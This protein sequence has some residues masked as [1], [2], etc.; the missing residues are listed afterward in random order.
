[1]DRDWMDGSA[2]SA[3]HVCVLFVLSSCVRPVRPYGWVSCPH[4][5][6]PCLRPPVSL[7]LLMC[8]RGDTAARC[9]R[10]RTSKGFVGFPLTECSHRYT[11]TH[12]CTLTIRTRSRPLSLSLS[13]SSFFLSLCLSHRCQETHS[14]F[15]SSARTVH[16]PDLTASLTDH[17]LH[18]LSFL[19]PR[20]PLASVITVLAAALFVR[21]E[22]RPFFELLIRKGLEQAQV[23]IRPK[24][25]G[26]AVA[27]LHGLV[28]GR[29]WGAGGSC[30]GCVG[31][32]ADGVEQHAQHTHGS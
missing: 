32:C 26:L 15:H 4:L 18:F 1:M 23:L 14:A 3:A 22:R 12:T 29:R 24:A 9:M 30:G 16:H 17:S 5:F 8:A 7:S 19:R 28:G 13:L 2:E 6:H 27:A 20:L 10:S 21:V 11:H 25:E 31:W